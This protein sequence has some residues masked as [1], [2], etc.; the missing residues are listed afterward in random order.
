MKRAGPR[1]GMAE[2]F[3]LWISSTPEIF[4]LPWSG[5]F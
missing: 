1:I 5:R 4:K 3:D 2:P